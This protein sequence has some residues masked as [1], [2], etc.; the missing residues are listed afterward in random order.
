MTESHRAVISR[1]SEEFDALARQMSRVSGELT[2][3]DRVIAATTTAPQPGAPAQP[4]PQPQPSAAPA[5]WQPYWPQN[6]HQY[7]PQV[8]QVAP[9]PPRQHTHAPVPPPPRR[10]PQ[11]NRPL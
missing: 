8:A 6:W 1:L 9:P 7:W 11:S 2:E 5:Y 10:N 4:Q 3:L